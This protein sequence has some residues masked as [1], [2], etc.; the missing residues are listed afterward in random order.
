MPTP[1]SYEF[2][3]EHSE[4]PE[5]LPVEEP[6]PTPP[7][8]GWI[9]VPL[10]VATL[11][12][13]AVWIP[14]ETEPDEGR[15][16]AAL[17]AYLRPGTPAW[18]RR[19]TG[20]KVITDQTLKLLAGHYEIESLD[21][22]DSQITDDGLEAL[23]GLTRLNWMSL[24]NT[25]ITDAGLVHLA[26]L[27][28]LKGL[29]LEHTRVSCHELPEFPGLHSLNLTGSMVDDRGLERLGQ[30]TSLTDIWLQQTAITDDGLAHLA[31]LKN[32]FVLSLTGTLI[33]SRGIAQMGLQSRLGVL[34]L[35]WTLVDDDA[36]MTLS[37]YPHLM[38]LSLEGT[39]VSDRGVVQL[40]RL[41]QLVSLSV[42]YAPVTA[43]GTRILK[44]AHPNAMIIR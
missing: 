7:Y 32:L 3:K 31:P 43:H 17:Q 37:S 6:N 39:R 35:N 12:G 14:H 36:L 19:E 13:V 5:E 34:F 40:V 8:T 1:D 26:R 4:S 38:Q 41:P 18:I 21:L 28:R 22:S 10:L 2:R 29:D 11:V 25:T 30:I 42:Q 44:E 27:P 23:V 15:R 33:S 9:L 16:W 20:Q 24:R